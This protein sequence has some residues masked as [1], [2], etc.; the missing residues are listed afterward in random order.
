MPRREHRP[1]HRWCALGLAGLSDPKPLPSPQEFNLPTPRLFH[2]DIAVK[3]TQMKIVWPVVKPDAGNTVR[4][5]TVLS[6]IASY[7]LLVGGDH[8]TIAPR[9]HSLYFSRRNIL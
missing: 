8:G 1:W 9:S 3:H 5:S 2:T 6:S 4:G 7:V